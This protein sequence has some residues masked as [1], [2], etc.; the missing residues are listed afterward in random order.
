MNSN[1]QRNLEL[2]TSEDTVYFKYLFKQYEKRT[3][4]PKI[5]SPS[6]YFFI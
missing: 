4:T 5:I 6:R 1:E 3:I 2:K